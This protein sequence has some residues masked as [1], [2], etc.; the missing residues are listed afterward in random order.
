M[1]GDIKQ[2]NPDSLRKNLFVAGGCVALEGLITLCALCAFNDDDTA[3]EHERIS[4]EYRRLEQTYE[5]EEE[6]RLP[7]Y[8]NIGV[9]SDESLDVEVPTRRY[10]PNELLNHSY[11]FNKIYI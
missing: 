6:R 9:A 11:N 10:K 1:E 4:A 3:K 2:K 5:H 8:R 7:V